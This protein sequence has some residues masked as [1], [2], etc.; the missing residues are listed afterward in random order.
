MIPTREKQSVP[1]E[2]LS[3]KYSS[4][5]HNSTTSATILA[6]KT[7]RNLS[8]KRSNALA[9]YLLLRCTLQKIP[10]DLQFPTV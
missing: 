5:E 4:S 8:E 1:K 3:E 2:K 10:V 6:L 7:K 9:I